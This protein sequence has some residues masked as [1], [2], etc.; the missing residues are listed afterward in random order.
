MFP[1]TIH[2]HAHI[3]E[4]HGLT[5][6]SLTST[7]RASRR[8]VASSSLGLFLAARA[9]LT[10]RAACSAA[11]GA[12]RPVETETDDDVYVSKSKESSMGPG[13]LGA[14]AAAAEEEVG[15]G[16]RPSSSESESE[17]SESLVFFFLFMFLFL[18]LSLTLNSSLGNIR[19]WAGE[20]V[21]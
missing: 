17:S 7:V 8:P 13:D 14:A 20:C 18:F 16:G 9:N 2:A 1:P 11:L 5:S 3:P 4:F 10:E 15:G 6:P 19:Y 12:E 21:K